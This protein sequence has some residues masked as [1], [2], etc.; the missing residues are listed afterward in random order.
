MPG[1]PHI[2]VVEARYYEDI[3]DQLAAGAEAALKRAGATF[4]RIT[5]PG[6]FEI[7]GAVRM[8]IQS[9]THDVA[10]GVA[11]YDGYVGL[12]CVIRGE[13]SHYD[14]VCNE[15]A[16]GLQSLVLEHAVAV[17]FGV[18]TV[19]NRDQAWARAALDRGNKGAE[20]AEAC[21]RMVA[22]RGQFHLSP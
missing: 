6:A 9:R 5:V 2:L 21:L 12:G 10:G 11:R 16:R 4:D 17:G 13:T 3:M 20:A 22:L 19:E 18:L 1:A 15:C 14:I 8:A 7:P